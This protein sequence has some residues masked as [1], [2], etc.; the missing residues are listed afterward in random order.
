MKIIPLLVLFVSASLPI[1]AQTGS[2]IR[3]RVL[4][5]ISKEPLYGVAVSLVEE[6]RIGTYTDS[7]G[8]FKLPVEGRKS[9]QVQAHFLGYQ[10]WQG[11]SSGVEDD[12]L[13]FLE[14]I[15]STL[16][17]VVVSATMKTVQKDASPIPVD[18]YHARFFQKNAVPNVFEALQMVNG[19][20]P[21]ITCNVCN[22]GSI[23]INGLPGPYTMVTIDGMPIMGGLSTVYGL[24]G[25]PNGMIE[26]I[27]VSKGPASTLFGS[28]AV[29]G[30]INIV[31]QHPA[32]APKVFA[33][34]FAT[35]IGEYNVDASA[36]G[37]IGKAFVMIGLNYFNFQRRIDI[38]K[39]H[40]TDVSL[41]N[42][43]SVFNKWHF[44]RKEHRIAGV[45]ARFVHENRWGGETDWSPR[46]R[47]T[48]SIY[49]E[50]IYTNRLELMGKYQLPL[51]GA[52]ILLDVSWNNHDQN[53]VYGQTVY[54]ARQQVAFA[55]LSSTF[56][57]WNGH[58]LL[59]GAAL[60]HTFYDDNTPATL[61]SDRRAKAA[62]GA[63][64]PGIFFQ[65]AWQVNERNIF[66]TG[67]RFDYHSAHGAILTP[68]ASWKWAKT[69][70]HIIRLTAGSGF[71]VANI[72]TED[73][74][75]LSGAREV[76][77]E[78]SLKPER[79]WNVNLNYVNKFYP[80]SVG[81]IQLDGSLFVTYF[82][83]QILPD[84]DSNPEK[85]IYKNLRGHGLTSGASLNLDV[86]FVNGLKITAGF[87]GLYAYQRN[88]GIQK[89][90]LFAPPFSGT[91]SISYPIQRWGCTVD[92]TGNLNSP[93]RLPVFPNDPRP[94]RSPWYSI[95]NLQ[96]TKRI[97]ENVAFYAGVKNL[98][99]F[100]PRGN[101][102]LRAFDPFD[103][104][105][106]INNPENFTFDPTYSYAPVL[107]QRILIGLRYTLRTKSKRE[108]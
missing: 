80:R 16:G 57:D 53:S 22:T 56:P 31:T 78:E 71:R 73:H 7:T 41:Q 43:I 77:I 103:K 105:I 49:G 34:V 86:N 74:A 72:F 32:H 99:G 1:G 97:G 58:E 46:W 24:S 38:N 87:T 9:L 6:A 91:W 20:R 102:I 5:A 101:I 81:F 42:R 84:Y 12:T 25:I 48:D 11:E 67:L 21:Q 45:A 30:L 28:E 66:L 26:Q 96:V 51:A 69:P 37:A 47:G 39:D 79:S 59:L 2:L 23:Q 63:W 75:A 62:A 10:S 104:Q 36:T 83:N 61:H 60:R 44:K 27:E 64:L 54:I 92:Y 95:H 8:Q 65:D 13:I 90:L 40:F 70:Q 85:I 107:R 88:E 33:D 98:F 89:D 3:G 29:G 76:V 4:D 14:P 106:G 52:P 18:I 35:S 17:A 82:S 108:T 100:Y 55:Q 50:S 19:V 15:S 93:M 68:R 94:E